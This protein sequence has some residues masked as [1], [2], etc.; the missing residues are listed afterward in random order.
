MYGANDHCRDSGA[1]ERV[2][3]CRLDRVG[4]RDPIAQGAIQDQ[5]QGDAEAAAEEHCNDR[6][7]HSDAVEGAAEDRGETDR[8]E[9]REGRHPE[10]SRGQKVDHQA[11]DEC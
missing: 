7:D 6:C 10:R 5:E 4:D 1:V 8:Q 11:A 9:Q 2:R 3:Q